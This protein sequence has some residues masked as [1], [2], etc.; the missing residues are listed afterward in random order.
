M[1]CCQT[2]K[3]HACK[4]HH[5]YESIHLYFSLI[6]Y[7]ERGR[8]ERE[9]ARVWNYTAYKRQREKKTTIINITT[10]I[11]INIHIHIH[12]HSNNNILTITMTT[13]TSSTQRRRWRMRPPLPTSSHHNVPSILSIIKRWN[14]GIPVAVP[15]SHIYL[16]VASHVL[17][18]RY[19][20]LY[21]CI[22]GRV[23][24]GFWEFL[25]TWTHAR[26]HTSKSFECGCI[27][28]WRGQKI[29]TQHF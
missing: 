16:S 28:K 7:N 4:S 5:L 17:P 8:P 23:I 2:E 9:R 6:I 22:Y 15:Q 18:W 12:I 19:I 20:S 25:L 13:T 3:R 29:S 11:I 1:E 26:K 14:T 27:H 21:I 24:A 10:I